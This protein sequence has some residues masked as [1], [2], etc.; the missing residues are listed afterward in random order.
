[1]MEVIQQLE[2]WK[3]QL[4][5]AP[6]AE[7]ADVDVARRLVQHGIKA[8]QRIRELVAENERLRTGDTCARACEGMAYRI[9]ARRLQSEVD[10]LSAAITKAHAEATDEFPAVDAGPTPLRGRVTRRD[11]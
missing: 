5:A 9:E 10:R 8:L 1:M 3:A 7:Y 6:C 2:A 11:E 4:D